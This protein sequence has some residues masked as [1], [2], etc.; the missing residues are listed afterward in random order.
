MAGEPDLLLLD[1]PTAG[2]DLPNQQALA[3]TL[4]TLKSRG[5]TIVLVAHELGPLAPLIDRAVVMR[6]GQVAYDGAPLADH[7]VHGPF[8]GP[9]HHHHHHHREPTPVDHVPTIASPSTPRARRCCRD[10]GPQLRLHDPGD[11]RRGVHGSLRPDRR[12]LPGAAPPL[13]H[14]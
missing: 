11:V 8:F 4:A 12:H 3:D 6:D 5:V 7:E 14:G 10:R 2:V 9:G 1:E 13:P